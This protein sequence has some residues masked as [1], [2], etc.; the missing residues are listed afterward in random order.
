MDDPTKDGDSIGH[1]NDY[2]PGMDVHFSSGVYNKAFYILAN[3][4]K[5]NV[6]RAFKSFAIANK[7][8]WRSASTFNEGACGVI[9]AAED[10]GRNAD[11]VIDAFRQVGVECPN[12]PAVV[13]IVSP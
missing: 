1:A 5:W 12:R 6:R 10:D 4:N 9:T 3:K 7:M 13:R 8:Y 11:D 2:T